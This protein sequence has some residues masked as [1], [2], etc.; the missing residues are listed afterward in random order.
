MLMIE[1]FDLDGTLWSP[2]YVPLCVS[3]DRRS[4]PI[5]AEHAQDYKLLPGV[6]AA[7][8]PLHA[9]GAKIIVCTNQGG[10]PW[11]VDCGQ[12][13][14]RQG[15][16]FRP[17]KTWNRFQSEMLYLRQLLPQI[18]QIWISPGI[19]TGIILVG[20]PCHRFQFRLLPGV[21]CHK[22]AP[23]MLLNIWQE[24][25]NS[26]FRFWGDLTSDLAAALAAKSRGMPLEFMWAEQLLTKPIN[27]G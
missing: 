27:K 19:N 14:A 23:T 8:A 5:W 26:L 12:R 25:P 1:I 22:P 7:I 4:H 9:D 15:K 17:C 20:M 21:E 24:Y 6:A 16:E 13:A 3:Q 10:L 11:N 2:S 18:D